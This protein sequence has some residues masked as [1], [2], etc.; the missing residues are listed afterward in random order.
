MLAVKYILLTS[1]IAMFL[2]AA[3]ILIYDVI[4]YVQFRRKAAREEEQ[5]PTPEPVRWRTTVALAML[6]WAPLLGALSIVVVPSGMAGV[7]VRGV[8]SRERPGTRCTGVQLVR[9]LVET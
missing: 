4:A 8:V 5:L 2:V 7:R 6:A 9:P 1:A 3:G